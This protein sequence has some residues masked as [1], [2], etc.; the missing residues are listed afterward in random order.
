M[1]TYTLKQAWMLEVGDVILVT[2]ELRAKHRRPAALEGAHRLIVR[3]FTHTILH[4][5]RLGFHDGETATVKPDFVV[6]VEN[7]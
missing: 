5:V 6:K 1:S 4:N 3:T 7:A 2:P